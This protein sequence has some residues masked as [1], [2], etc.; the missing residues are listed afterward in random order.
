MELKRPMILFK[1][2]N[3]LYA[4]FMYE[5]VIF[6]CPVTSGPPPCV[7][8]AP[9]RKSARNAA[10]CQKAVPMQTG[11]KHEARASDGTGIRLTWGNDYSLDEEEDPKLLDRH[12]GKYGLDYPIEEEAKEPG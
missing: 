9:Q 8:M 2:V 3:A 6:A 11:T 1:A 4:V 10:D 12:T 5:L 7:T